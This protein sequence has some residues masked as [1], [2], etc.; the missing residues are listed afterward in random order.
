MKRSRS[1]G[2]D[3]LGHSVNA[4]MKNLKL[5]LFFSV[6][7]LLALLIPLASP[8]PTYI[9]VGG[10][11]LRTSSMP[12]LTGF[13][14]AFMV[15]AFLASL[16][17]IS[18]ATAAICIIVKSQRTLTHIRRE[19][20]GGIEKYVLN[21]FWIFLTAELLYIIVGMLAYEWQVQGWLNP[22]ATLVGSL[23]LVYAPAA[24][25]IDDMRPF[26]AVEASFNSV[27]RRP[28][29]FLLWVAVAVVSLSIVEILALVL[30]RENHKLAQLIV[31]VLNSLFI[32][33]FLMVLQTQIYMAKYPLAK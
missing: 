15:I 10:T 20:I 17:L 5:M 16:F 1:V 7:A 27:K 31:L 18:F 4:Y 6:P 32:F 29:L 3:V 28:E 14:I 19:V 9:A 8:L 33:P 30:L 13:D 22:L 2:M 21:I 25:V 24:L 23:F 26:R 11:Y 12:E